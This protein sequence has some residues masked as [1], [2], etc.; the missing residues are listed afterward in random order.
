MPGGRP[1]AVHR[2]R[3]GPAVL[4]RTGDG[5]VWIGHVRRGD[6]PH[7]FKLPATVAL[8]GEVACRRR[9]PLA[10]GEGTGSRPAGGGRL[11]ELRYRES[12]DGG[13]LPALR[14]LQRRDVHPQCERLLAALRGGPPRDARV[15]VLRAGRTSGRTASTSN[16]IEAAD[17]ARPTSPGAISTRSTTSAWPS[18]K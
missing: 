17:R 13:R 1:G 18:W 2:A 9:L 4:R 7:P 5:A 6:S 8:L 3:C 14:L 10:P 12:E 16:T 15:L 11:S